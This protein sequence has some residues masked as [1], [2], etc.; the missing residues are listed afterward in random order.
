VIVVVKMQ[1]YDLVID[2]D[3]DYDKR[4]DVHS[5]QAFQLVLLRPLQSPGSL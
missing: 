2:H 3:I 4:I 1:E 5:A